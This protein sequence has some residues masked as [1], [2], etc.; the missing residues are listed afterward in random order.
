MTKGENRTAHCY[1]L[2]EQNTILLQF[3]E[4]TSM[5]RLE[6]QFVYHT[7]RTRH[8]AQPTSFPNA[9]ITP[10]LPRPV[11]SQAATEAKVQ[12]G[13]IWLNNQPL[14]PNLSLSLALAW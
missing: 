3:K 2:K 11:T 1:N 8:H 4:M 12:T 7:R 6:L 13:S 9:L 14:S 5:S 10:P